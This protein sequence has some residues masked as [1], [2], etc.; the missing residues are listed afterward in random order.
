[1]KQYITPD[2]LNE[3]S[4]KGKKKL[5]EWWKPRKGDVVCHDR[6]SCKGVVQD[7]CKEE[8]YFICTNEGSYEDVRWLIEVETVL[9]DWGCVEPVPLLSI[10]QMIEF[11]DNNEESG[12]KELKYE[13]Y[14]LCD[15]LWQAVKEVLEQE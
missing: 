2:Q 8:N 6:W 9:A 3:L 7:V 14:D 12:V 1:M 10:G 11:V 15:A 5:R 4:G 13:L